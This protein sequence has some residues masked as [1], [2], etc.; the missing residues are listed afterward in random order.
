[1][2]PPP[3]I[4]RS[5]PWLSAC[6]T[7]LLLTLAS[8]GSGD[9]SGL[10]FVALVPLLIVVDGARRWRAGVL[11]FVSSSVLWT[12]TLAWPAPWVTHYGGISWTRGALTGLVILSL[13]SVFMAAF[14]VI[15]ASARDR[16]GVEA[17]IVV[18]SGWVALEFLRTTLTG[19]P[20]NLLAV[21]QWRRT[22]LIQIATI[23]GVYGVSFVVAAV[24]V[25]IARLVRRTRPRPAA[26]GALGAAAL[27]VLLAMLIP[28]FTRPTTTP[29]SSIP[30][31]IVQGNI[32][33]SV[34]WDRAY[35]DASLD[36]HHE[37][38]RQAIATGARL[39]IWPETAVPLHDRNDP[40]WAAVEAIARDSR[41]H[42]LV[43]APHGPREAPRNSAFLIGP[44]GAVARYDKR[45]LLPFAEYVPWQGALAFLSV[46]TGDAISEFVAGPDRVV[47]QTAFGRLATVI[48]YEAILPA[49]TRELFLGGADVLVNLTNDA[50][51]GP[52]P[53]PVQHLALATF[54]AV[55]H[56][57]WLVRAANSGI[58]AIVAPDGHVVRSSALFTRGVLAGSFSPRTTTTF[59]T[60]FGDLF[61]WSAVGVTA[62]ALV[63]LPRF[64]RRAATVSA[65]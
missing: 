3:I 16:S 22:E 61:A 63:P 9:V 11:G 15:A 26:T 7:G 57:T 44:D 59:Y 10:A 6:A 5:L 48:C 19:F 45:H 64:R 42:L 25:A 20:W 37:L 49:E 31:A 13:V 46:V 34:K 62:A 53:T 56:R 4:R 65:S 8:P 39:V 50:W 35:M 21:T 14:A 52:T 60:R 33:Q 23:T 58:S 27:V 51:F 29:A 17:V 28:W 40:R 2:S 43:G 54:R 24:N 32:D 36:V 38:T 30:V 1:V 47:L 55:E 41:V 12:I 18:A